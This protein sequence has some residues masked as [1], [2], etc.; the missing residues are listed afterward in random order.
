MSSRCSG[1]GPGVWWM[2]AVDHHDLRKAELMTVTT[3]T[4][5]PAETIGV[6]QAIGGRGPLTAAVD[7]F[8]P[9]L[10]ADPGLRPYFPRGASARHRGQPVPSPG[11]ALAGPA[12]HP[13]PHP[14]PA[15]RRP[16]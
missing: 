5:A 1:A 9:R 13:G 16:A 8:Y 7:D 12:P 6:Y 10:L 14:P 3:G 15:P 11:H 2:V 4:S